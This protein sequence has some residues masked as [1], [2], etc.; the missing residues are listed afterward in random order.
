M[1]TRRNQQTI[2]RPAAVEGFGYWSGRDVRVEFRP[3]PQDTGVVFVRSDLAGAPR[4][5]ASI[6]QRTEAQRR[7]NLVNG[8]AAVEMIEHIMA[9][10]AGLQIDNCEVWVD[11]PEMPGV[12][13]SSQPFVAALVAAGT[14]RQEALRAQC[15]IG[16]VIRLGSAKSWIE[17]QPVDA[18]ATIL[19]YELDY[20]PDSPIGRQRRE[21]RLSPETFRRELA[22]SRTFLLRA[23]AE[24][25]LAQGL[26]NRATLRDLLVFDVGGPIDNHLRHADECVRHKL[27]DLVGDLAMAGCDLI[28]RFVAYRSGHQLNA[29]LVRTILAQAAEREVKRCA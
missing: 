5:A 27:L 4:I 12:D 20:G 1:E 3:A 2:A 13:G 21:L 29:E 23:E 11:Q 24:A 6:A 26:G 22:D 28:G 7:T 17:V 14:V 16:E 10:L 19:A 15:V 25:L 9:A 18:P 8:A